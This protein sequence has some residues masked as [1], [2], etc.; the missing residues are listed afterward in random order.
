MI[1]GTLLLRFLSDA[2]AELKGEERGLEVDER[3]SLY[4][5][6]LSEVVPLEEFIP[7]NVLR[8]YAKS[9]HQDARRSS[10]ISFE[11]AEAGC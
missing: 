2:I 7:Q 1:A 8:R 10:V 5:P 11:A 6:T 9:A 3:V 4:E